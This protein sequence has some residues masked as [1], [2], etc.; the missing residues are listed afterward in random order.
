MWESWPNLSRWGFFC[1]VF[2]GEKGGS[3]CL[4]H[5]SISVHGSLSNQ[6]GSCTFTQAPPPQT[7]MQHSY[8]MWQHQRD[9][10]PSVYHTCTIIWCSICI[11][12]LVMEREVFIRPSAGRS[13]AGFPLDLQWVESTQKAVAL[14]LFW[15]RRCGINCFKRLLVRSW[16]FYWES[17]HRENVSAWICAWINCLHTCFLV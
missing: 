1:F 9:H 17:L 3:S 6:K 10:S 7:H 14:N 8:V 11:S 12:T 2:K 4:P 15:T 16:N 13:S 5:L